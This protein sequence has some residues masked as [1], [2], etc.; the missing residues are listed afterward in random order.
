MP[1]LVIRSLRKSFLLGSGQSPRRTEALAGVDL[2]V[3]EGEIVGIVGGKGAGKTTLLLCVAGLLRREG[4][5]IKWNGEQFTGCVPGLSFVPAVPTYYPFL[6]V[7]EVFDNYCP[8][9]RDLSARRPRL[10]P[11][12]AARLGLTNY[13]TATVGMLDVEVLKRVAIAQAFVDEARVILFDGSLDS[14][15]SGGALVHRAIRE[16]VSM[17]PTIFAT[18][19]HAGALAPVATRIVVMDAGR[20][21]GSFSAIQRDSTFDP[22]PAPML[23]IAERMH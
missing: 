17:R 2:D 5:S 23:Q 1:V 9:Q 21:T 6:T 7:R 22:L 12:V 16:S 18:S 3:D 8:R 20:L 11:A 19:R 13:L 4:G 15:G 14:L 10:I